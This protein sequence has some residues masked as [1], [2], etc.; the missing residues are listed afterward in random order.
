MSTPP[1]LSDIL[2]QDGAINVLRAALR[3]RRVHH[4]WV[5][6][7]PPGVGK[8]TTALA[9]ASMLLD[10]TLGENLAG[11]LDVDPDSPTRAMIAAGTHPDLHVITKELALYDD[12]K[13][14]RERKL[15]SIPKEVIGTHLLEPIARAASIRSGSVMSKAFIVDEAELLDRSKSDAPVQNAL[16]KTLEEPPPGSIMILVTSHEDRLLTTVRSRCQRVAFTALDRA[17]MAG[18]FKSAAPSFPRAVEAN[19][20]AWVERFAGGSPGQA[21]TAI[22]TGLYQWSLALEPLLAQTDAG[23]FPIELGQTMSKL[24]GA[25]AEQW[26]SEHKNASKEAANRA[27]VRHLATLLAGRYRERLGAAAKR[28]D[29]TGCEAAARAIDAVTRGERDV[30]VNVNMGQAL[31]N[32]AAQLV[33]SA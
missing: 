18:W 17:S 23:R 3:S 16:L 12:D 24:V 15:I 2:G 14:I 28:G 1:L 29:E 30:A 31:E 21:L 32:L 22:Q 8:F 7:G 10:P 27:A 4:A 5:F 13:R 9:F 19:E 11:E 33:T 25:W 26:V 20:R 6:A